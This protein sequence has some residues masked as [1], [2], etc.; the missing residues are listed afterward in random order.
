MYGIRLYHE[1]NEY[2]LLVLSKNKNIIKFNGIT[3]RL[4]EDD[5]KKI[6]MIIADMI[7]DRMLEDGM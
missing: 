2:D 4:K 5:A 1:N 3:Y 6:D 7:G